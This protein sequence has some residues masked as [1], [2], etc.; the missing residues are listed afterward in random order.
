M[1]RWH[2]SSIIFLLRISI[3]INTHYFIGRSDLNA[4]STG[5]SDGPM[6]IALTFIGHTDG[7]VEIALMFI[8]H[9]DGPMETALVI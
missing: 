9:T 6:E 2:L 7:L 8:G 4:T 1:F 5:D 3:A